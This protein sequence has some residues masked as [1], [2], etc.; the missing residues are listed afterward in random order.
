L[1][2]TFELFD[3]DASDVDRSRY[4]YRRQLILAWASA[5]VL[6]AI[7][8]GVA[9]TLLLTGH[10]ARSPQRGVVLTAVVVGTLGA[11]VMFVVV[12]AHALRVA[13]F[14]LRKEVS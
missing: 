5:L 10:E 1:S 14:V 7:L 13:T 12:V 2:A 9:V 6:L 11:A 3:E 8:A 4:L